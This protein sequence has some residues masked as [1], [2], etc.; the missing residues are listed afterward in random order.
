M[1]KRRR[2]VMSAGSDRQIDELLRMTWLL[3]VLANR[4][5]I[6]DA[7]DAPKV[8]F[9]PGIADYGQWGCAVHIQF[10]KEGRGQHES[11]IY[12]DVGTCLANVKGQVRD[13]LGKSVPW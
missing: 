4:G 9:S 6:E 3:A 13:R 7:E 5:P 10:K 2:S 8:V 11:H 1:A 12:G